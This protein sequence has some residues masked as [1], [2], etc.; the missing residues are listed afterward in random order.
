MLL[1]QEQVQNRFSIL[2]ILILYL[3]VFMV[4]S[5]LFYSFRISTGAELP[6]V[7]MILFAFSFFDD[8]RFCVFAANIVFVYPD[9]EPDGQLA[10]SHLVSDKV[11]QICGRILPQVRRLAVLC[12]SG[13]DLF[14][15]SG[16]GREPPYKVRR[17]SAGFQTGRGMR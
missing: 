5:I 7:D 10:F 12:G 13:H 8:I 3:P 17:V 16:V 15:G 1:Q 2:D 9:F 4:G 14:C 11:C 6:V